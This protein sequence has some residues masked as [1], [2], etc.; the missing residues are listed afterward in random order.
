MNQIETAPEQ[1]QAVAGF[2]DELLGRSQRLEY[3]DE[4]PLAA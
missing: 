1:L 2:F 4:V 3:Q